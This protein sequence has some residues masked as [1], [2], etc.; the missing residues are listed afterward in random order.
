VSARVKLDENLPRQIAGLVSAR[1]HEAATV[2]EQ[3]W[4]GASDDELALALVASHP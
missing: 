1:G 3:G 4:Q 2:V